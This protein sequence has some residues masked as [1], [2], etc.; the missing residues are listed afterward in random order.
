MDIAPPDS[1]DKK[2]IMVKVNFEIESNYMY[3]KKQITPPPL[4]QKLYR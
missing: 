3:M 2:Y 4:S 1:V